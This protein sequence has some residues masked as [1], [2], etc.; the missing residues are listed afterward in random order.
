MI[1]QTINSKIFKTEN[2]QPCISRYIKPFSLSRVLVLATALTLAACGG[3]GG[4]DL[5]A[6]NAG[7]GTGTGGGGG[8]TDGGTGGVATQTAFETTLYPVVVDRCGG[9]HASQ[10]P[11]GTPD[12]AHETVATALNVVESNTLANLGNPAN[13]RLVTKLT[14]ELHR[15]GTDCQAWSDEI[16]L[17]IEAWAGLV[18]DTGSGSG[19]TGTDIVSSTLTLADGAQNAGA[20]R[21]DNSII[22]KYEFKAGTG[23]TAF[24]T[25]GVAPAMNLELSTDV[26]WVAGEGIDITD[27]N[28]AEVSKAV[29]TQ[30][31]S[32]K[33]YDMI[34]GPAGSNEYTIEAWIINAAT[35]LAGPARIVSYSQDSANRNFTMGQVTDYY[36]YRNRSDMSDNNGSPAL[37][38]DN[39]AADLKTELQHVVFTFDSAN[40]RNIY[41]NGGKPAYDVASDPS[42]PAD[43]SNWNEN[44]T[45]LLGNEVNVNRQ[46]L[47]KMF[48]VAIHNR[49]LT[50][51]EILQNTLAGI[52][53]KFSLQFDVSALLDT[54]GAT[55]TTVS[56]D[57]AELDAFSYVLSSPVLTTDMPV[58]NIPVK[59][60]RIAVNGNIP[61]AA[62]AFRNVDMTATSSPMDLSRLGAVIP[63][64][65]GPESDQFSLVF[66]VLGNNSN[67]VIEPVPV[68]ELDTSVNAPSPENGLRTFE[69]INNTMATLTGVDQGVTNATF[70]D[71][72]QQLPG[73]PN[74][75]SFVSAHQVGVAKLSLEYCDALVESNS[76]RTAFVGAGFEF[77][78]AVSTAFS[79]QTKRNIIISNLV[80]KMVGTNLDSQP[81]MTDLQPELDMLID[82][83]T[84]GCN[85]AADCNAAR[86]RTVVKAA[87][88]AVLGSAAVLIQ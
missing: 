49:A 68:A 74:L 19:V 26:N 53:E 23:T 32:K 46:W 39:N 34:A 30:A 5:T 31:D 17:A 27:P 8:G 25:S 33:L 36:N 37:E 72:R 60:I 86:T 24:D 45:F 75:G 71:L 69:Q 83:L 41:I 20:G 50:P 58:P 21:V 55:T 73:T 81:N 78:S 44:Y 48:F 14:L 70:N 80:N 6:V 54:T 38:T 51:A 57:V 56:M 40:G 67:V 18:G 65:M 62:Q 64:D 22:A 4:G 2:G 76:L 61:A 12:F 52:G 28:N 82:Q 35:D 63:K 66:E 47:G 29:A 11:G 84:V 79:N 1:K 7:G 88:A 42:V 87:C 43:I 15:C 13:S 85:V 77:G 16:R 10:G 3:G 9:C 59:N